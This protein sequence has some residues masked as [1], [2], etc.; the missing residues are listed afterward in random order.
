MMPH[1]YLGL[2]TKVVWQDKGN[3]WEEV[4]G[5]LAKENETLSQKHF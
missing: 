3:Q 1:P 5:P 2:I 4:E